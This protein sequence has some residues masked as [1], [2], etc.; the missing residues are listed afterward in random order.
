MVMGFYKVVGA[1][2]SCSFQQVWLFSQHLF[3]VLGGEIPANIIRIRKERRIGRHQRGFG[4]WRERGWVQ[5]LWILLIV[6]LFALISVTV[7]YRMFQEIKGL[8]RVNCT[9]S[10][11][12]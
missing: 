6:G 4:E 5:L 7:Y 10:R 12:Y 8:I 3:S 2:K 11:F 9:N 1:V